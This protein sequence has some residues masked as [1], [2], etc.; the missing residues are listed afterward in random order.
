[1]VYSGITRTA[2]MPLEWVIPWLGLCLGLSTVN[3]A[4][5]EMMKK[6]VI[7]EVISTHNDQFCSSW[8]N[9]H[10]KTFDGDFVQLPLK[11]NYVLVSDCKNDYESF[12][13]QFQRQEEN[14]VTTIKKIKMKLDGV[15]VELNN[16]GV[17]VND[18]IVTV[19]FGQNGISIGKVMSYVKIESKLGLAVMWNEENS[20]W[21]ELDTKF[22]NQTCG[23][24]G[25]FNGIQIYDEFIKTETRESV[26]KEE[27]GANWKV[28]GLDGKC[29]E[30]SATASQ[31]C[32]NQKGLCENLLSGPAFLSCQDLIDTESFI[33]ACVQDLCHCNSSTTCLCSTVSEFSRQ[34]AHAGG[35]PQNWQ[36]AQLCAKTCP[37]N[38]EYQEC[39]SPCTDTCSNPQRSQVCDD[40]CVDGCF[41]PS[42][43]VFDDIAQTGCVAVDECSCLHNGKEYKSGESY[44]RACKTCTCTKGQWNCKDVDCPGICS[45]L[46]GSHI[47]TYDDKTYTFHG[48]CSY[49]LTKEMRGI[50]VIGDLGGCEKSAKSTCLTAVTLLLPNKMM[51][52][53]EADGQVFQDKV[54]ANLPSFLDGVTILRPST[55]FVVISTSYGLHLEIQLTPVMQIYIKASVSN[56][57]KLKGLCGDFN[58][59]EADDFKTMNGL[60]EGTAGIFANTWKTKANCPDVKKNRLVDPCSLSVDKE[61]YAKNWCSLLS[62]ANGIFSPCHSEINPEDYEA[63]CIY[64]SCT[65]DNSE[66][67]M[68]AALSSYVHACAAEGVLLKGWRD[69]TCKQYTTGCPS[70]FVY[71]Y[72][73]ESCGRTCRSL[74]QSDLTCEVKFTPLDGCGCAKGTYLNDEGECVPATKCPCYVEDMVVVSGKVI[75]LSGQTCSCQGG[76]LSCKG[77]HISESCKSPMVYFDCSSAKPGVNGSECQKS[78]QTVDTE[79]VSKKCVSGCVCPAGLL[80]DDVGGCI[81]EEN[82]PCTYHGESYPSGQTVTVDCN[83]CTCKSRKWK[84][85]DRQCDGTC[86]IY[87]EGHYITFDEKKFSFNGDC[88]Y[89][90]TQDYC[91]DQMDGTFRVVTESIPC[92]TT[93]SICSTAIKLYLGNTEIVLSEEDVKVIKQNKGIDI[94]YQVHTIGIYLVIEAKNGLVLI[95]NKK[96]TLMIKLSSTFKGKVCGLCGNYDGNIKNDF[97]TR[98][99]EVVV[100]ALE[101]GNSWKVSPTCPNAKALKNPCSLYSHRQAW[102]LKHCSIINSKVFAVCH[103]KVD[104]QNYYD[105]C[106]K[107]TCACNTGGD[108]ECFCSSVAAYAAACNKAGACIKWRTPTICPLFCDFY[109]PDGEC[110]WHYEPCGKPCMKTCRNPSGECYNQI[111]ELEGCY[112]SCPPERSYLEEVT[113][114]CVPKEAC[115]CYDNNGKHYKEGELLP[116]TE[117]CYK[118]YCSSTKAK[119]EYHVQD[120]TCSY[121]GHIYNYDD[122]VYDTHDGDGTCITAI[123]GENGNITRIFGTCHTPTT[124]KA[125][126]TTAFVFETTTAKSTTAKKEPIT[127]TT[128][129]EK[130]TATVTEKPSTTA[131]TTTEKSTTTTE[132]PTTTAAITEKSTTTT[133]G[134]P[135]T[136]ATTEKPSTT[137]T[138]KSTTAKKEPIT[139]TTLTEK[140]TATVT[141][142]PSTTAATTTKKSSTTSANCFRCSWSVWTNSHYPEDGNG[143][144]EY[145]PIDKITNPD[146]STCS[147]PLKIECRS[148]DHIDTPFNEIG[149]KVTCDPEVGLRCFNKDQGFPPTCYDYEIR[150]QCCINI[151]APSTTKAPSTTPTKGTIPSTTTTSGS[152]EKI[153][154]TSGAV[155]ENP[156]TTTLTEE[157]T[158]KTTTTEKPTAAITATEK[159]SSTA[160]PTTEQPTVTEKSTTTTERP[161]TTAAVTEKSTTTTSGEPSTPA[162]TEKPSTTTTAKSTTAKKEPITTTTLTEKPTATVTEKPSTTAATTTKKSSTTSANCFRCSW[163]VWTNSHYPEDGNGGGEYEPIDK[164]TN[165]DLST[166]SK[167]LKIECRSKDHIDTPFN[168]IGQKVT[169]DPEVGLR[170]FNKDQG[171]PPTCYDYEIRVQC[172]INICAPST[173]KAPSTTPT[174][175]TIPSTTTT[176]GSTEKI[177]T[178][179]GAV[180]ENPTTTTLTEEP[181][182][183]TTTT[184]KPTAAIT[185]TEKPSST[186]S[187][188]TEQPTVTEKSTTTT[189]RPTTTAAVTEK[190]TTTTSGEPS[191]PATTEKP[192]TTT[193]A[194]STTAKKEPITTT[195]LTEKPTATV[196]EKPSTTAATTTKKSSTTSANC[197]RCSWSVWT[198]SHYPEDGN[199]GG[200]YE[201]IDKITNP[202]LSTCSKPLK[203]ECR[204]KDHIDTPFNEIGQKVT[205]DPEV[206]L[207]CFNKDQG[208]PP[209]C[210]DYEIRVQCCVNICAP[211]TTKAPSTTPTKGTIPSTTTTSGST[212]KIGTTSGAVTENPTTTTLT[213]EP[214]TKTTTT[215]KPTA[216][217]TATEKPSSTASPTTEQPT[218]TEKSTTTTER[219]TTTAA[220]TEKS[221]TTTS[222]EPS[223]PATTEKPS[224]TTTAKS[225]TAKKEPITTTT[226]TEKPTAT[227]TEKPSTTAATTTKKSSTTSANCFRCS[228]SVWTN[229]HYPEDGNGG[230]EYEPIDKI[231]NPDLSTCSKPLKIECRSKDHIDTPF[232]EIGQKVTCDP[233]VGLRCFN[234]DQGFPPTCYDYE[235]RV[236]CCV[237]ICAPSTTKAPSTTPTKGT[238]PS[239][240]TTSG[241]TE[242]I[243]TTSGAVTENP[244]TTTLTEEPTT[245]TTTTEKPTA[246]IT[247][248]EKP[249]ST[250]SPTTEQPTVTEKSTTTTER[251]TTTAAVTE[252]STTTTSG[253]PSTPA[254]TEKPST[255]TTAK[256]TTAKKEPITTTTLTEKPTATVTK[257]PSTTAA[258]TTKK[259]STTSA[260]CFR[261]SWSVWTNS[262]YPE[263]GNGG[264]EYEPIDKITNPDLSTCSKP[265]KIDCRS[266]DHIDTPFNEIGQKVTCDPEVGLRCFNKDQGFPPTCYDYEIRVQCCVNICAPS[267]TKAPSTTPT[268]GTIPSTTTTSGSTEKIGTTSG[269]VTENPTTTTLTEEPTTK[270]TT[271]EKPTATTTATEKPSSTASPTTE[272]P[273]VTEKSTTTTERPTTTAAVTEKSTTTTSGE[274]STPAT[275]E[276]PSTTTTAKSTTAKKEPITTTTLTEKPTATVTEKPSTTAATTT[277]KSS[278][279]SANCFRC[280]WSVWTNSHYPEDGNGGGEY[281]P[282]DKIK[283]PDLS[284]C[285]KPLKIE[286]RSKDHIDTPFNEIGQ[287]VTCD[288]EVGLKCFNK[289]QGFP[290]TC[291]DYEIRVQCCVNICA[292]S[293]TKAPS[294]TPTKGTIPSTTTTSGS[295]EKIGT[296]SGAVTEN[297]TTTTLTEEPTTK[298]TTTEKPTATTTATE[299]PSSTA[300]PTTEQPTVTEKSTTT[301][302]RPTTTAAVTEKSTTTTSG[303]P[304]TPATTE[305]PSTT[306]TAKSTTAKKEPTTT[307]T[308]TEK[309]GTTLKP[310]ETTS[311]VVTDQVVTTV[312]TPRPVVVVTTTATTEKTTTTATEKTST[313]AATTTEQPKVT[314]E[315]TTISEK[316]TAT[317]TATEKPSSTASPTTEQPTVTEKSTTTTERPTTTAAITEKSTTTTSGEPST[318]ATTE[319]PSTTTT[320]KSTTAKKEPITTTTLTEKPTA[321][322]TEKPSTTA[323]TTTKKSSTTS[324][325]CF[326][327]S[328]SVWTNSHYPEDGNG[329]GEYEPID[330]ITNPDLS[331]CSKPL[332]IE[333]R[334]KD[335]IDTPFNEIGQKVTCDPEVGLK[336]FNKDQG[337]PP[338]CYD[339]EI[340]VQCCVNICAPSTTKAPSTTPTKGTIPST[341]TTSGSTEK[342]GTTSGAVTENPMT[343]TLTEEPTTKTTTTEKPT[344]TTTATEKPSSTASPT[345]EQPTV[346]E[347]STTTTERPTTTAAVTEKST[348]TTSGEPSTPATTEKSSTTTTAKSTTAKKEPITTTTLTE[349]P[350]AT[351]TEKPSTTA[352]TTTK[353]SSTTS[354]NCFRCS[355]SVWTNSHYPEDGNGGGEYEPIDKITNPDLSTCSKPLKIECRSKDHIDT[356]FNEIGQKVTC[357]PEVG[358]KCFNKD[359]GFPPTCYDYEIRVQCCVNIC[360]PSTTKAPST[361]PTKGTIPSTTTTSGST[362]KIG[363]TS[364]AVTE[365][366]TTTTLTEEPT[367]KTTTTEKPTATTTA[368]EKPSS[369]ASP[370]TEQPTVTEKST[371]TT[372]RPTTTAAVTEKSTTTTS[373]EP[374][375][376]ATTEKPSTTTTA[377]STTAKKEPITTTTLTE[378]PTATVTEKP[379]TTAATTTKKSSTTSANCFRCSWSVWTNS[380]YPEDGNGGGEYEP[381]DKITNPDLSTCSK[382]LKIECRSK[383]HIDTPFNEIGQ[384]VTCDPE[385]GLKCFNKDQGFPPTCYDYEIRVQCCVNICAPST[386]KAPSTT[387]TKGTIPSTTTTSGSTEKIGTT[388]GAVTENPMTTTL[389][390]EP[391][392]KTTTTEKPTATTTATEKPSS[393]ASPTTEQP[394]VTEKS[395]TTTERPTTTAAVT[396]KSTT[397]TSGEPST[398]ATTEKSSTTTTA[399]STTAKK[400]PITTTTLTEKPTATVTEKPSTTAATTTKKS[401]TTSANCFRCSWSVWTNSHYPEDGNGGGEYEPID[402]ITNPDLSTC[403]KPLKIECRSKDHIDT[404][405]NEIGQKVTCDPEVGLKC[406][407]KDQGFP[408]TCYDYEIRVQCCVNICAPSTTKAPSTTPTKG[409]IPST[410]TTSGSTEKIGTTSGAVTE[411]PTTTTLTEEPTTKTTTTE[412][413]TATTTATEKPSSTAS[414]TTEQPTVTEKSTTTTERPT[415]T[416][417]VTEKSTTTTSGEPSTPATTEKPST[418]TTAKSTTA[419]KEPITTTTLTEKPTATVTEKPSTTAATTT[420]KSSTTSAN[421]FRCSWSVWTNSH[422]PEDGNGGG[423]YEPID[424]ITNPDLS[425][426]S[427]PLKIECRSKDHIDTPFNEIGQKVTCDPEVGLKCFNKDQGFPPT[428]YDYEIRVQCC[429]N[430]CAPSTTKAPST[431]PTKGTIPST[432]TT[433]GSTEKIGTT[434]GAVTENPT[435]TTLTEEP[436]KTT[437]TEKPTATTTATEKPSSTASP[438][439]EQP[440]VTEKSTTTTERPTTAAVTE[441]STTTTSGE[442]ST[443]ATT[444]K[445]STTTTAKSTTAKKEP[446]TT[447]TTTEKP[448]TTLKPTE[449]TSEV[450]TDQVVTTVQ[451]PRPVVV[452]TTTATTEKTTTTATEKT[453]TTAATTTE[454]P[455]VTGESTTI[456]EKPTV[457]TTATEKPSSTASPT[458][459]QPTVTEKSTTTTERPTTTAAITEKST[460][461]TSGEPSTPATTEKPSTTTTAKS[462]TAKK[463]PITTTTL[464]E[465]PTATVTEKPSTTAATTTKKSSTTSANCFRCSW[466]VWT[467]S[468]YPEDGNGGGEYEPIDKITNPDLSTC[469]KPLK[470]ECRSKDHIDTP[471]NEIG[472]KVTCDPEVGLKCFNKD[473]GFPPTCYDYEIRVQCCVNICA[474]STTK[475]PSTTPTKGTIPSTTTTSGS[476]EKI[477]TTSGAVTENPTTTTLTEEPTTKTTTTEKPTATTTATEKPSSTASPTTEQPTVTE[478]S[479]TT[480]ERPTTT[481]AVTEKSTT[482]TSGEPST[483]ATTEKSS[484]TTTAKSTTA[485]KEPITTT[486]LTE[487]PTATVTEKP[488]TTAATTTK[489]SSTTSANCFRCSWSVWTNS[490]YPEDGNGGGEYE[491]IDKITNPDLSTCSKPLKIECRSKDHIDTPFNEIGQKVTCDPEVGLKCFNKDQG[492]PPTCYDYEIRVQCC[493]NICAPSTTKAPS[494]TPTKGTIPSTTTTSGSTE[495]IGTTSGAVTENPTT[496]TLTEEPTTKTTTTEKPTAT[497]TATEKPSSTASPTTEQPTVT[498]KSTTTTERPTTTA[499]VTEKST[500]TTSGEPSTPATTEKPSTTTTAK[501]TTAKKEPITTTTLTEKPTATVTEKPSTTAATTTKK[502]STTSANC[503]RCSWSVWTNSHYPEDGNGGGEYEPIDKITNPDLSTCSKPLKIECRSKDHIDTPF[504]EIG[505]KVTCDPEVGLKCFNKDQGF[506]PTCYDY[507]I[508]V[509]CCVNICAPSTTKAPSTTPT[510]GTIPSTTTTSGSTE[511]IGTTSGAVTENPTTT[512]LT[513]EPT[514]KTTTTEKPTAT[515]TATEKPSS[516]AS[517]T[518]E[519]PTVTEKSTTTTERPTT[520]AAVTEKS[521]TTTSGEPSTPATTEKPSTTTTAKST[522]AKKEPITTTTLTEKPTATVTEKP[523][524]TAAT[525][526]KKSSTTS[527]NCFRCSWSVWTNSHYPEDGNGGGEYEPI[528]KITNPDLSTCSKPLKIECRSKDHIDTPFNEIGQKVTCDPEVG[529]KCF[530]KDQGF[531]PTCYD[532]E[533]RVQ[534]CVNI[535]APS[536]TK[537]P[538]T[539]PTKGTIPSTTTTS[540]STEKIGTTSGAVT[541]NPT[542]TTLTEEPTTKTTTTE[543]PTATTTAT[544]KPSSTASPTTEQPTVTEKSTTTTERPTTTAAVTEKS[545]TTTSGEPSTPATTEKPST[546]TTAKSTTAKKEPITT[547][548]LTEK[549]TATVTE[550][551]STTAATTTKKSSTTSANCF[552]CSWSVWTNSHYPEDGNGGGEYEPI[553]KITNPDLS[554]CSKPLKIECRSKDHIDTPFNEIGQKVT[555][556]PEVGLKCFNKDQGFPPTCYDYEIRVQCC[557]NI[558]APSTTKAPSTTPTKGTIPSTTTTSGSTEK[559][560]TTSGAVTENPTTTTLTEEPTTK[561]TTTEKP[562]ATTTATEKPS[563]T[564]SPTTEQPTVTEK[565]T[566]TTERPTT[567]AAVTE[568]S[569]TTTSGE[570]STPA[571]TEKPSTTT[572]AKS[573]T[574]KKEPITTTTLTEKPTATVTEKPSTTAATTTKKSSTTSANCFRCSWS[575][576]TNSHYPEDGNGGGE[577]EPIDKITNPDLSTCSKPLKIECRSKDHIDTPFNEIGQKVTCD[578]EVGLKCFNKDQ[579][580]PPTCYDYEIRVQCCVNICAPSTTK[581]PSTTP[582]KGT[583]P[584]TTT[585]SGSTEKIGTTS[586]AVTENPTTTTLTEEPTTKTTTTEKPTAT[587]TATEKPSSTASPTTEQPTVTEKSTTTTERPTTTAAVT[588]KSTTTTSGEPSTPATTEK[589]STTTTAKSTTAKKEP[590]TTTTLTEK[591]TAT[592]TEKPSTT[593]ATTTKKSS[594]TSANCFRCSWSVWTN[595]HY[596]EDG[597]GGGEYEPIDK[598]TNPDL[599]TCSKPLKI[600]CRSKDHIDTPFNEIGQKVTCDPEVGLKC[601][602]KDQGFPP[603]CYDYEIRVQCCVNICA[604]STTK[605]PSTTPTKGTIPSTTTTSGST[606]KIGTTSGAVTENPTTTTLTEEPTTKT[607]TTEKPTA[608]TTAT[609]KPSSTASPTTEQ[610][611]VTE[612]STTTTERPT[613]TA[614]VTEKSTTT[615]SGEPSTPATT[616]KPSTT[617]TAKSTTAKKEPITTTTLTEKP[618]AT[619]T[620]KPSTTAATTTKKSSTTSANCFRCS[621]SV[622]TNS[623]Y[624]EDGNGG[625]EYEPIDKITNPDLSTCSKPLKIECRSKDHIDTPFNEIGQKVTCD[626]EV[627]LKCFNKDQGF[628]PTCYDYEIRV[629]CCVNICAP[630]TTKA[631]STT[632]TKGTIPSTTTTSGST[633]KIGTTSGAV[634]ENPTTTTLTEE[635][636]TKTTTT[637][638]PTATTTATEKPS[639]TASPTTEQ[640]TVTEKSTTTTERPTTTAAVTEKSTT[641]TSGEPSTPATTEKPSTTTTAKSTTAKKEPITTTTLTEKP[642][643]TVTEKPSTT[644]ATTTK[645]SSTTSANCFRCSWSVWT[646]SHYPEDGN[647]GGE[648]EPI[649]KITNPDLSTCSKPLKIECRSKDHI[650]TPFNEIG[651]KVTCDPEVG[652]KCF[653]KD[654]GFP[655]TCYD[656]EIRVQCC[657]NICAP[658]TTKAPSTTP[659]K[660]TIPSTTTTSGSTEKIGTTSGAVTENPTTTTLTEE[661]TTKTTTTEKPTATT[662]ATEKP[663][664]TASP[665][666]EQPTVTEKSTTTT[667]RPTTTAAVTEKSTTT[668]SGE[669]STPATTEKP[670]T[671]TTAKSTT[672]KKEPITTTTLTEK[673]TAT[674]T[675]KPSTTAATTTKKSSTT[676]ANCF[677]CSWS[678]WTNS[679][680]PEDGNGGGEYEPIDKITNPDLST[681]SKP[682]KIE[683]RSKDHIDTPFNEIGQKVTCDPEVGLKCFNKDQGFPPTCYDYEIRVQCCVNICAPSTT[684]APSTTPTKGTIPS[685]TTTSGS[686]EKI[687]TTSGAVTENP[688]TTTLTEEPTTTTTTTEKPVT[689]PKPTETTSEVVTHQVVTTVQSTRPVVVTTTATTEKTSTTAATTTEQP[690]VTGESTTI[691]EKP[692]ATTTATEKPSSTASPTTEQ[693]TVT[694]QSTTMHSTTM[695]FCTYRNESF[696]PGSLI[697]NRTD[698]DGWCFTSYCNLSCNVEKQDRLCQSTTTPN[699]SI[700]TTSSGITTQTGSTSAGK[701]TTVNITDCSYLNPPRQLG[702][703]WKSGCQQCVCSNDTLSVKCEPLP[704]PTQ[705]PIICTEDGEVLVNRIVDC[706]ERQ[707]CEC[708]KGRCSLLIQKCKP[709]HELEVHRSNDSCCPSYECVPKDVCVFNDTEYKPGVNFSKGPC[710]SCRCTNNKDPDTM[711][712]DIECYMMSCLP[713][714]PEGYEFETIPGQCCPS[715]KK[716][717]CVLEVPG[718]SS[719][720]IIEPSKSWSPPNDNCTKYDCQKVKDDFIT[721]KN[722]ISCPAF[723]PENCIPGTEQT[724]MNGCCK[725]CTPRDSCQPQKNTTYLQIKNCKSVVEV[726]ITACAG[727]CGASSSIYSA[728][729]NSMI[730]ACSC[731]QEIAT[732]EKEVDM[733]CTDGSKITHTYISV[734]KCGCHV[735]ECPT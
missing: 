727:S 417:A 527:A 400:E 481:A 545:T 341:T 578:P 502:S 361:T 347:K 109:N 343:T 238:I 93:E 208:F 299:K 264:G 476:T 412:K 355:W 125:S 629:Q 410:T 72:Q 416:A 432:T 482:T 623:H 637:E 118:C 564:A 536:T 193:T 469:S 56:K 185:A 280:S 303:E 644:A 656:Y 643:A 74:S 353:K 195:T 458:T 168:E 607:T 251:P 369:T 711:L 600:E 166:C 457:T 349:K 487:K 257:K 611:T 28:D 401:S 726:E 592:V 723:D 95:W 695:C 269:A 381:I 700:S 697:Y 675:E 253:E 132:R 571:T 187:P 105:A 178:T 140:P 448:G 136:P 522:T 80:S 342:I 510:K 300:S 492:F 734:D 441:K 638:K 707:M 218:V 285:S 399:K 318:P 241:S 409:T 653:N 250:A 654:Q 77:S 322:V 281:E 705:E 6:P 84:C 513:E 389:T 374:S 523:S 561:T 7:T 440:T 60:I 671:T 581:A 593:A 566:T 433:S 466:S 144:G 254:T 261:C 402:K 530:N 13:I 206:G 479:T 661:P 713:N 549:P 130:P 375:T 49:V 110:E 365:N 622:W 327:C 573:T 659:T 184:E 5:V 2:R 143:G 236:Q 153:G 386:T 232:N 124:T 658:S 588:E 163:S 326:R 453:S 554:T 256:S 582:T 115:G 692:T 176:S 94:P 249:S 141:E 418:T 19:P 287:K 54:L 296:T 703:T 83:T 89:V 65:C 419:K 214:T 255:T 25:D 499:A 655:P 435:T 100:E 157:P 427:K 260:N 225:T 524:T 368:T 30:D 716:A 14:G 244:T 724:D 154:T 472:Q 155:T 67:C 102:A 446:T 47:S 363:T 670:S 576:W 201:P 338:T 398:P 684:K 245:K 452:V 529:L 189:E 370:T 468:H 333:C 657:V 219:P 319:K 647:G 639:S 569:T 631:P 85:T 18:E 312:Q 628:P 78:C 437:T 243:G 295:T 69:I 396:E 297:P 508:R 354:A 715:C 314:G 526:T 456:S 635:P 382:P 483:P 519:Q 601:F 680:Y 634:T 279:T 572:T 71:G 541:E 618:T 173:T 323:A 532:Y 646:N 81:A 310:T 22:M 345:T 587:T 663:S 648:Y 712:N 82:C 560:G 174:K 230:G 395:T 336:C 691:S 664:S 507:E 51:I 15:T 470:I 718:S 73:M 534:C 404:P 552:R 275:T 122:I 181:T 142:K 311:E 506:P 307:T 116:R 98:N 258:T 460:T 589:P 158:T 428:C 63:S 204:S 32:A 52:V 209:T 43:T 123:C 449:T 694:E 672:A 133:S 553:D 719:P 442:P 615:T 277:K 358:L 423:E 485:K 220:V 609:E 459:E 668:T 70:N 104:S 603:T 562:T 267:T 735:A 662:T 226:L 403:S 183:K 627:G 494:T 217:T 390:E 90:F 223:T 497:T 10:F 444:E 112:P 76:K 443:P 106:V 150:V 642:T 551:P 568:K 372:E 16:T 367:T 265:L 511:K 706:C 23:L 298:T 733:T 152:T 212:E 200:E 177:G 393:T 198:N 385:V 509:Q 139:T 332:K 682:L 649:D 420:K 340:R 161:T 425:T 709:G 586:G 438:T 731:C 352:A 246:A 714:C 632:P 477:G 517:P 313:T 699:P 194:K 111:P 478:K 33:E 721:L 636:T 101:F 392:T 164:I 29:E 543:K 64:D 289:D 540:G 301:T 57:G 531:P 12:N 489:K 239:T 39:E 227:V 53:V 678:V 329:G 451:T 602:N 397:T 474:P 211:S 496:T 121:K 728:E 270:T 263:D 567:T 231:T 514:T 577:Y 515:T 55:F 149:Q 606:E 528:D 306:T 421:C 413:P 538:S 172:C 378:K 40:H 282:I 555:C 34:C 563:S 667:E 595:S 384:K 337:F 167:P 272:Q 48:E 683:C 271:T 242:K 160:S 278:T 274:P 87:G 380:H 92:G 617:T 330:K 679:H 17:K 686:T 424:K 729:S 544:E 641:T 504:N 537:A 505:Q 516:T 730:H 542:T 525:T 334:S 677:R 37:F 690:K 186:A 616:E 702:E 356:P 488:S 50:T 475:A 8:G 450:V 364:G 191:T 320:A 262:H 175:G 147:K 127:T 321:T 498:E 599:S 79:C 75:R 96:T 88:G 495:K 273:T 46:G 621:W 188:T 316:P 360:A 548:T 137:T 436:T 151:C 224:T 235:I 237:N 138:A 309:P 500:T 414:P 461:T 107:D 696:S 608:T 233:E 4:M 610:P 619:V 693:P 604:P 291:Y 467:N 597:N 388:S 58:D 192:S 520:T 248:T 633:E 689:T 222:G 583:I 228:W 377:K 302:E 335:H 135:S 725:T 640:P 213:E 491:P 394:T 426:C 210:Y 113:M 290:P 283:N 24:C 480:T 387:P 584:S 315:S 650:D 128:L 559:I 371:T 455:K 247:A 180:T 294:T 533:I 216:T 594:T 666:T 120:C 630:S 305:K 45:V 660:G 146:L 512:T 565:S 674:V 197:F 202:D 411:N 199:G 406:F 31:T 286:C 240:T 351:V 229:S 698:G 357:D 447:T 612:K 620:E 625:G 165:P 9:Y 722:Q 464:T 614:A 126:T 108:C 518:T 685:T 490:H 434:S 114:K 41:C 688:T 486:T 252:K 292:P 501:S 156:T 376:P 196:T 493:V 535:C 11:C 539:T 117:N 379:S 86:T 170:C 284:T 162:T 266:K 681:C 732:S 558:C 645:K 38:M 708:D 557:V 350:T 344:A 585:T 268:K 415:T 20:L 676:S 431:T 44:S 328:W 462:T 598:I 626:P 366:P 234:K 471:F 276:K 26:E 665:T 652:L 579:G 148:K 27:Y 331:T 103:S 259:S 591:P 203:I 720:I 391:T 99:K 66:K 550:K 182:T 422:Y 346:T 221:T 324:A 590:I 169:C 129:I 373:G 362:E 701:V 308:T 465:K 207:R 317:T 503:F 605:A 669:P 59:V 325:N 293:T 547:T 383:D 205:C 429:V 359:Q 673:P 159:P 580:F 430:I 624:P 288:P 42:G 304:S 445:P 119:C 145:E 521:T 570:P 68:C 215:E 61:K 717:S 463:E 651:Q 405:F 439:T 21:V 408:P 339:Y 556:D 710:E 574:A 91:G 484:T 171:F 546:T 473:Q 407:N 35:Q 134:E 131:A 97:T 613:T 1:M 348:T 179:S 687:G 190:S 704:C 62:D 575:V 596:P 454:Q 36:T 3:S